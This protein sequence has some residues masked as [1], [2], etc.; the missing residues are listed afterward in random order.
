MGWTSIYQLF[1]GSLGTRVLTHPQRK[2][3]CVKSRHLP[4]IFPE[5]PNR[6]RRPRP[7]TC[8]ASERMSEVCCFILP[9]HHG[10]SAWDTR[11]GKHTKNYGKSWK[12]TIFHGKIHY[13]YWHFQVRKLWMSL[14]EAK[15]PWK[16]DGWDLSEVDPSIWK[17]RSWP[18]QF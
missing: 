14:P 7:G 2:C 11:P 18:F 16:S 15:M 8:V 9:K 13:F 17:I 4:A 10:N 12:I 1:W 5:S 6:L 3:S